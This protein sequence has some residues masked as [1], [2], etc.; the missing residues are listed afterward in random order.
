MANSEK[1][2]SEIMRDLRARHL[3]ETARQVAAEHGVTLA[4][5]LG[6][7]QVAHFARA[8]QKLW[9][10]AYEQIPSLVVLGDMFDRDHT[11]ILSGIRAHRARVPP[12]ESAPCAS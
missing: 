11:T 8:R 4:E 7:R 2:I 10:V 6:R 5:M 9:A 3:A 1:S 12:L